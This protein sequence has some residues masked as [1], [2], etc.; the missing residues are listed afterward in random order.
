VS[1]SALP[2]ARPD[3]T[4]APGEWA[5]VEPSEDADSDSAAEERE[6]QPQALQAPARA[7]PA[8]R[9][10]DDTIEIW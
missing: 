5:F 3:L 4:M 2:V 9:E 6:A 1:L 10:R 7:P 8:E